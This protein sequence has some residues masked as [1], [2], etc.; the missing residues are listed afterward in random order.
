MN[1]L[2]KEGKIVKR[3]EENDLIYNSIQEIRQLEFEI[4]F[5]RSSFEVNLW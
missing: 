1:C 5:I 2:Y 4:I 3:F